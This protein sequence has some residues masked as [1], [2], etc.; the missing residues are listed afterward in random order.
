MRHTCRRSVDFPIP[1]SPPTS[2]R[3]PGTIPPPS[4]RSSS[5]I[6]VGIRSSFP[7]EISVRCTG[8]L[9]AA[10][11]LPSPWFPAGVLA[12]V[13]SSTNVFHSLHAGHWPIHFADSYPQF[14]QKKGG[15]FC[16]CHSCVS[17][18]IV[19]KSCRTRSA[20]AFFSYFIMLLRFLL[21]HP[22]LFP[23]LR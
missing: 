7:V 4:T 10:L 21:L 22:L 14:W 19:K 8:F 9:P 1:G 20:T 23:A 12:A 5:P 3:E 11:W 2:V 18:I 15:F 17:L 16:F 6:P 13:G